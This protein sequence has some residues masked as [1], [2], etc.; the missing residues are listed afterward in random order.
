MHFWKCI[1][2][3]DWGLRGNRRHYIIYFEKKSPI[4]KIQKSIPNFELEEKYISWE[5]I[6][7][8]DFNN[9]TIYEEE[10]AH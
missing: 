6:K 7:I 8:S 5:K 1:I 4:Y 3:R 10:I 9:F 2:D